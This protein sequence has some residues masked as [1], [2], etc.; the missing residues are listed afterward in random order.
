MSLNTASLTTNGGD[1]ASPSTSLVLLPQEKILSVHDS[2][3]LSMTIGGGYPG[4]GGGEITVVRGS[5]VLTNLRLVYVVTDP[6]AAVA[7]RLRNVDMPLSH[8]RQ[9]RLIRPYWGQPSDVE[10]VVL[11]VQTLVP[12]NN[13]S[14]AAR[15]RLTFAANGAA[16]LHS[17]YLYAL[18]MSKFKW[19]MRIC[20]MPR[21]C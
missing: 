6:S 3:R 9:F 7:R 19:R 4:A 11:P 18:S 10:L 15:V 8:T 1:P 12:E 21:I 20:G 16:E 13:L 14:A 5:A 2:V 17:M